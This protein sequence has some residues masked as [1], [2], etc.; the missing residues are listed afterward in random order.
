MTSVSAGSGIVAQDMCKSFDDHL[1]LDK[2]S[3]AVEEGTILALLGP[4]GAGKPVTEL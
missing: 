4:N 2:V 3:L 1:V